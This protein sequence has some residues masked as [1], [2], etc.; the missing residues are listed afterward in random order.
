M[1]VLFGTLL[2]GVTASAQTSPSGAV[3]STLPSQAPSQ[4]P[5]QVKPGVALQSL[6]PEARKRLL[7]VS[8]SDII[9]EFPKHV[10]ASFGDES[11]Y[12]F[13]FI[14]DQGNSKP[15]PPAKQAG[16]I[17]ELRAPC[18]G[19]QMES[20]SSKLYICNAPEVVGLAADQ[21]GGAT[22]EIVVNGQELTF[23]IY[24]CNHWSGHFVCG[25][26]SPPSQPSPS[27]SSEPSASP[28]GEPAAAPASE[29]SASAGEPVAPAQEGN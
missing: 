5:S 4:V 28:A 10:L 15:S 9:L 27:P 24:R 23:S 2:W 13:T 7:V 18:P 1:T 25:F 11:D 21:S 16:K 26:H 3:P 12:V 17:G 6:T 22:F 19:P 8:S 29:P 14:P 20:A